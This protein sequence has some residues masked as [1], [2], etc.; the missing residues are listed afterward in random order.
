MSSSED[1]V[2]TA[3]QEIAQGSGEQSDDLINII[4]IL[5]KFSEELN[6]MINIVKEVDQNTRKIRSMASNSNTDMESVITSANNVENID[7]DKNIILGKIKATSSFAEEI[8]AS[9]EEIAASSEEMSASTQE[10]SET[11]IKLYRMTKEIVEKI[12]V[13]K[14]K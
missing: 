5:H 9:S 2:A 12:N 1:N 13:F 11:A 14:T 8:S 3:I 6:C 4:N 10:V 7:K